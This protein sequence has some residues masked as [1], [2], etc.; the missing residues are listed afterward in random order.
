M[1]VLFSDIGEVVKPRFCLPVLPDEPDNRILEAAVA[2]QAAAVVTGDKAL[3]A[4]ADL[5]GNPHPHSRPV[6][7]L[8]A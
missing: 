4:L 3:P 1:A 6:S 8:K 7:R 5:S 2:G